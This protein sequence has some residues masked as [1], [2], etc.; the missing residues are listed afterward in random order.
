[1]GRFWMVLRV[2]VLSLVA[3]L[4]NLGKQRLMIRFMATYHLVMDIS[5]FWTRKTALI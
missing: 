3:A 4:V 5:P 2:V 1:M